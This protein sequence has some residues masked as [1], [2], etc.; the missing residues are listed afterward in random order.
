MKKVLLKK[1]LKVAKIK[2]HKKLRIISNPMCPSHI[3]VLAIGPN[4]N[5]G[6]FF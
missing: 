5:G 1:Y 4:V 6:T 3:A 2:A